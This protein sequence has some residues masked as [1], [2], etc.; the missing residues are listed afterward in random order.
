MSRTLTVLDP[1]PLALVQDRGR[2]GYAAVGLGRSGAADRAS[3]DLANRLVGNPADVATLEILLGGFV[4]QANSHLWIAVTGAPTPVR[5]DG[6]GEPTGLAFAL[7]PGQTLYVGRPA[8]GMR[9]YLAVRG[10]IDVARVL[11]SRSHDTL[12]G[13][14]PPPLAAGDALPIGV[15]SATIPDLD[16]AVGPPTD[17]AAT[18]ALNVA[19]GPRLDWLADPGQLATAWRVG[20]HSD[21]IGVRLDGSALQRPPRHTS[22]ELPS[23]GMVRGAVQVPPGGHPVV[24]LNDHP[25]TG[26]YPVIGVIAARDVDR[27]AQARPGDSV[28]LKWA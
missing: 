26:G 15:A 8:V 21:R 12:A 7:R 17:P 6:R 13:V 2:P 1:G 3:H 28:R 19:A 10:G 24:F 16:A 9:T 4:A 14:G 23:E 25:V 22:L 5:V 18:A 20:S 27:L 11:G